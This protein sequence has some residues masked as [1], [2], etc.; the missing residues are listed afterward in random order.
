ML[1]TVFNLAVAAGGI[2]GG[3]LLDKVGIDSFFVS[4]VAL[5]LTGLLIVYL[6]CENGFKAGARLLG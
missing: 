1:V 4:M 3:I 5:S 6:F 2:A